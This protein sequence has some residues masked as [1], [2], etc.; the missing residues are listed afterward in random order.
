MNY[1]KLTVERFKERLDAGEYDGLTGARRA[2]GKA[3]WN[4]KDRE[5]AR[6]LADAHFGADGGKPAPKKAAAKK[7]APKKAAAAPKKVAAA[8]P[9]PAPKKAAAKKAA[10]RPSSAPAPVR[11]VAAPSHPAPF[12][13]PAPAPAATAAP[14]HLEEATRSN[15]AALVIQAMR[16]TGPLS[17]LEARTYAVA[18]EE[19]W[20]SARESARQA[21]DVAT[22]G[23]PVPQ[24]LENAPVQ[25]AAPEHVTAPVGAPPRIPVQEN[26]VLPPMTPEQQAQYDRLKQGAVA[27]PAILGQGGTGTPG[28]SS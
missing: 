6:A 21:V 26:G 28:A 1:D 27:I 23:V 10:S 12:R 8:K 20:A 16:G 11:E 3:K 25:Q 18:Q 22:H 13:A 4:D 7:P 5:R 9:A 2:I 17:S 19:Y 24:P 15:S 14:Y